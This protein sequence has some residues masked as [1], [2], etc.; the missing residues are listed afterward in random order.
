[1]INLSNFLTVRQPIPNEQQKRTIIWNG[2]EYEN[3]LFSGFNMDFSFKNERL[4][5]RVSCVFRFNFFNVKDLHLGDFNFTLEDLSKLYNVSVDELRILFSQRLHFITQATVIYNRELFDWCINLKL[6]LSQ[7]YP[8]WGDD[9]DFM[10]TNFFYE[11][12]HFSTNID[13]I[14]QNFISSYIEFGCKQYAPSTEGK[15]WWG[16]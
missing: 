16:Y 6:F 10:G 12:S 1:M 4:T 13:E 5:I 15:L 14:I 3:P 2:A 8:S 9:F 7:K 11:S